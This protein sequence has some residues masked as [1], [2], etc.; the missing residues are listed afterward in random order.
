MA[1]QITDQ[2]TSLDN[3][4]AVTNWDNVSGVAAGTLDT[5][6]KIEGSGCVGFNLTNAV[7]GLLYDA[8]SA[9]NWS[10]NHFYLWVKVDVAG[11]LAVKASGGLRVRFCG[12]TV[13]DWFEVYVD[14]SDTYY[15]GWKMH[16]I[17]IELARSTAVTN[18]WT[19]GTTPATSAIRYVGFVGDTGGVMTKKQDNFYVDAFW[20]L[21]DG[22]PGLRVEG[23]NG[24]TTDWDWND[25][26]SYSTTNGLGMCSRLRNGTISLNAPVQFFIND[27]TTHGFAD[28]NETIGW[29]TQEYAASDLYGITVLGG[30]GTMSFT[31]GVKSGTG[32]AATGSLGCTILAQSSAVRWFFDAD[33]ANIDL[34]GLYGCT[35]IHGGD[36]QLDQAN[37]E[38]ISS[39]FVDCTSLTQS[40]SATASCEFYRNQV[41]SANTADGVAFLTAYTLADIKYN[42]FTFSDGHAIELTN[43]SGS[44]F[45][46][47]S[48]QFVG[49]GST[50]TNDAALY[51]NSGGAVTVS[52]VGGSAITYRNGTGASTTINTSVTVTITCKNKAGL[53]VQGVQVR[54]ETDP[55]GTLISNGSTNASGI[56]TFSY[57]Y[58][59]DQNVR[60]I[61][62]LKGYDEETGAYDTIKSPN[63]LS[64]P[65]T[66]VRDDAVYLP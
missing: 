44:P 61:A 9:Q 11:L 22:T 15:G 65:L 59:G 36:F 26:V 30:S 3:A 17:D 12:N 4:N 50:G 10:N 16:V 5:D 1:N 35:F 51:N 23:R 45:T 43:N 21:P 63:G 46:F 20:R 8:G 33:D 37:V 34:V 40:S 64:V 13:T 7:Q 19:N 55:G 66:M 32:T 49:Y 47:T 27:A 24:G 6:V 60:V 53:A 28:T 29:E 42:T 57:N 52:N 48:N 14:G 58:T 56:Y 18:G 38:C 2:R 54:V 41:V 39:V 25:I 31:M 62:R